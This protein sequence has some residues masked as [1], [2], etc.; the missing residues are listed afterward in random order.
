MVTSK[1]RGGRY[2]RWSFRFPYLSHRYVGDWSIFNFLSYIKS[3]GEVGNRADSHSRCK[4]AAQNRCTDKYAR[5]SAMLKTNQKAN[6]WMPK[7]QFFFLGCVLGWIWEVAVYFVSHG[8]Q[9]NLLTVIVHLRGFLHGPWVPI[10]GVG[11]VLMLLLRD[12]FPKKPIQFFVSSM[13]VCGAIEFATSWILEQLFHAKW[14]DYSAQ[15]MNLDGRICLGGLLFFGVAGAVAVY[16]LEPTFQKM[17]RHI[18]IRCNQMLF[19]SLSV[20]FAADVIL[21]IF[22]PNLGIGVSVL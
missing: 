9:E 1:K 14:W 5:E 13:A 8:A 6:V 15:F 18:P 17:I 2:D 19:L 22:A 21:S 12:H 20:L 10:Y 7:V 16:L 11:G 4:D 3:F